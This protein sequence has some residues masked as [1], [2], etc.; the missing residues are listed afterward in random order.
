M[1]GRGAGRGKRG[2]PGTV[3]ELQRAEQHVRA[4]L[5]DLEPMVGQLDAEA[6]RRIGVLRMLLD[7]GGGLV[8]LAIL[9]TRRLEGR[10]M[11]LQRR[12][13]RPDDSE[14]DLGLFGAA[15]EGCP[16]LLFTS[17]R[18]AARWLVANGK[19]C[20]MTEDAVRVALG[21]VRKRLRES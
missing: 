20:D 5:D 4:F 1:A 9:A 6:A 11:A 13:G 10:L 16:R 15:L 17:D 3:D 18:A 21:K 2:E 14:R 12:G 8:A 19:A 7:H